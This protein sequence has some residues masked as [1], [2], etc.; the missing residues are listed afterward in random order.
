[1][2]AFLTV[3][4]G[5]VPRK[6]AE[7]VMLFELLLIATSGVLGV[8]HHYWWQ[9]LDEYWIA[10]GGIFSALEPLPLALLMIEAFK[11]QRKI[12]QTGD[13]FPFAIP[14][15]F[16]AGSAFLNWYG[17]GFLGMVINLPT[18]NYY[19]HG[20]YLIMP[21]AHVAMLGAFGYISIAFMY[22]VVRTNAIAKGLD[23]DVGDR[24][25]AGPHRP[26]PGLL[27]RTAAR[28]PR[29]HEGLDVVPS[30]AGWLDD[31]RCPGGVPGSAEEE[32]LPEKSS[33][34]LGD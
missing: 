18:I 17:A 10:V 13:E 6:A 28:G 31:P 25:R 2:L 12:N 4:L 34:I 15:L 22:L 30:C 23:P 3:A 16:L 26:R 14:F 33:L 27:G 19:A 5:L 32:L 9:G 21:H 8:G 1:V 7:R 24:F 20:T 11:Q 29:A